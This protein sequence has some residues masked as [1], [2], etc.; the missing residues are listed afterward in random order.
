MKVPR[1]SLPPLKHE[2]RQ[3]LERKGPAAVRGVLNSTA[4]PDLREH[5]KKCAECADVIAE[6]CGDKLPAE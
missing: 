1:D 5:A 4:G 3:V 6:V 2:L